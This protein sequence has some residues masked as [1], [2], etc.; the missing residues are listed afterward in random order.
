M[1]AM[2]HKCSIKH[3][4]KFISHNQLTLA[5]VLFANAAEGL[6]QLVAHHQPLSEHEDR[7]LVHQG[8]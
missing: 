2:H 5:T 4:L 1:T 7:S 8:L 3:M 6:Q